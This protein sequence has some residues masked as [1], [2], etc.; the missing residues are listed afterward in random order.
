M[1]FQA[2]LPRGQGRQRTLGRHECCEPSALLD[3]L[4]GKAKSALSS[5]LEDKACPCLLLQLAELSV[6]FLPDG[7]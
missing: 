3:G 7:P 1:L 5:S 2:E 4:T 6:H